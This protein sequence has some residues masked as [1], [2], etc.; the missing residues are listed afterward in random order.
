V[1]RY[2]SN[3]QTSFI[4]RTM[5]PADA[6]A[7][8]GRSAKRSLQLLTLVGAGTLLA[9]GLLLWLLSRRINQPLNALVQWTRHL[10]ATQLRQPPPAFGFPELNEMAGL[11]RSSLAT[12]Q[13]SLEREHQFQRHVSHE[14]R[15]PISVVRSN[16]NL[17]RRLEQQ[18]DG[19]TPAQLGPIV[20]RID[21]ASLTMKN[22]THTL[23]WLSRTD[24]DETLPTATVQLDQ[25]L[26]TLA[27]ECSY[28]LRDKAVQVQIDTAPCALE[29]APEP[30]RIVLAN[31]IQ[32]AF[33]HTWEGEVQIRQQGNRVEVIN[34][35]RH[36]TD[37]IDDL[38]FGLGLRLIAELTT[39]L[40]W[41]YTN[42]P[43]S[44]TRSSGHRVSIS[45]PVT[46]P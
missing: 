19:V 26:R 45:F 36:R 14:L 38:G 11:I 37:A 15:T 20:D 5:T 29:L 39:R 25:L 35:N 16:I 10:D 8:V 30:A 24:S 18:R 27:D 46:P 42:E 6:S 40:G 7:V 33:Q 12:V 23:L 21:R 17:L 4:A 43:R 13:D 44:E 31:I 34:H 1:L 22:L 9:L 41:N 3:D 28:L 2:C 32:N